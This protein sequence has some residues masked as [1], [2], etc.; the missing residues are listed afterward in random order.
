MTTITNILQ[1]EKNLEFQIWYHILKHAPT[2]TWEQPLLTFLDSIKEVPSNKISN[3]NIKR[4]IRF[5]HNLTRGVYAKSF[6]NESLNGLSLKEEMLLA[7]L[8]AKQDKI[9]EPNFKLSKQFKQKLNEDIPK[10]FQWGFCA[11]VEFIY[12]TEEF[13]KRFTKQKAKN[14]IL[15]TTVVGQIFPN[16]WNP[17]FP[18]KINKWNNERIKKSLQSIGNLIL[19]EQEIHQN[20]NH[21]YQDDFFQKQQNPDTGKGYKDSIFNEVQQLHKTYRFDWYYD[22]WKIRQQRCVKKLIDFFD[23]NNEVLR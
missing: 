15:E 16:K 19:I 7:N 23:I 1:N 14:H 12:E 18:N 6:A 17:H 9:Y 4:Y 11:I 5:I 20:I 22:L 3:K 8:L 13:T 2:K 21:I 10:Q